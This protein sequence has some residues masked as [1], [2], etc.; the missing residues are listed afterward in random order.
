MASAL[1]V[2]PIARR[3]RT[4]IPPESFTAALIH[5]IGKIVLARFLSPDQLRWLA[6]ARDLGGLSSLQAETEVLGVNHAGLGGRIAAQWKLPERLMNGVTFHHTPDEGN[7]VVCD[8]VYLAN[9]AAKR[10]GEG[11][12]RG[13]A[14][15][16]AQRA[17]ARQAR[18]DA[19]R[20]GGPAPHAARRLRSDARAVH[21]G[22]AQGPRRARVSAP[23]RDRGTRFRTRLAH[24][25][26][27]RISF[28]LGLHMR[29]RV[30]ILAPRCTRQRFHAVAACS[31]RSSS[32]LGA[33]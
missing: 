27:T 23:A 1:A 28:V 24:A 2:E 16:V 31:T 20:V 21:E 12:V 4:P 25:A 7:D 9:V 6:D 22:L 26:S 18:P 8:V 19:E 30:P 33:R 29:A 15:V 3:S 32:G 10:I 5:D 11:V 14:E 13:P 17:I